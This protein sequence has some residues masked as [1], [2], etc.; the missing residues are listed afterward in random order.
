MPGIQLQDPLGKS[1]RFGYP[2]ATQPP[3]RTLRQACFA[4]HALLVLVCKS[5]GALHM[6]GLKRRGSISYGCIMMDES[7]V[8]RASSVVSLDSRR[9]HCIGTGTC[10]P[11]GEV[12]N[13]GY[14]M[15]DLASMK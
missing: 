4:C 2:V 5:C 8:D 3:D 11:K 7:R 13:E 6:S 15:D 1:T 9:K 14:M 10:V 12:N